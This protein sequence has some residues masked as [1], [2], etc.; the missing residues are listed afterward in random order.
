MAGAPL[1]V[2][3]GT[4]GGKRTSNRT[5]SGSVGFE[6]RI[7]QRPEGVQTGVQTGCTPK[8]IARRGGKAHGALLN[9]SPNDRRPSVRLR[10]L[11]LRIYRNQPVMLRAS[12]LCGFG[13]R[14]RPNWP[15]STKAGEVGRFARLPAA[16]QS[17]APKA[18]PLG[19]TAAP[20]IVGG[21]RVP[22]APVNQ[23]REQCAPT[24]RGQ[25][26]R[27]VGAGCVDARP[28]V[29]QQKTATRGGGRYAIT[30]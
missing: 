19:R 16:S 5:K 21:E 12:P 25:P 20:T 28:G 8:R 29:R 17:D 3:L 23:G 30:R 11:S 26:R 9:C 13:S 18:R 6:P 4:T 14:Q 10:P 24:R 22:A 27:E 7:K 1:P 2:E 15:A